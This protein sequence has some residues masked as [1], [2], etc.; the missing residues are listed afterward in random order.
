MVNRDL[1]RIATMDDTDSKPQ[2]SSPLLHHSLM[3]PSRTAIVHARQFLANKQCEDGSWSAK[4]IGSPTYAA[5]LILL[6]VLADQADHELIELAANTLLQSQL[7]EGAWNAYPDGP[8]AYDATVEAYFALKI[9]DIEPWQEPIVR[10]RRAILRAGGL[11]TVSQNSKQI[12]RLFDQLPECYLNASLRAIQPLVHLPRTQGLQEIWLEKDQ[13]NFENDILEQTFYE[14]DSFSKKTATKFSLTPLTRRTEE[15]FAELSFNE[16]FEVIVRFVSQGEAGRGTSETQ[17]LCALDRCLEAVERLVVR[18]KKSDTLY[19]SPFTT[20]SL[21]TIRQFNALLASGQTHHSEQIQDALDWILLR[22]DPANLEAEA[23]HELAELLS[24]LGR[25]TTAEA[26]PSGEALPPTLQLADTDPNQAP[27]WI[28]TPHTDQFE[29]LAASHKEQRFLAVESLMNF[30]YKTLSARQLKEGGWSSDQVTP[31]ADITGLVLQAFGSKFFKPNKKAISKAVHYLASVQQLDGSFSGSCGVNALYATSQI[32]QGLIQVGHPVESD[33]VQ[34][35]KHW[36]LMH[37]QHAG[38]WGESPASRDG[39]ALCGEGPSS[40]TQT[41]WVVAALVEAGESLHPSVE[42][43]ISFLLE[44]QEA[45][46]SWSEPHY[47]L[48]DPRTNQVYRNHLTPITFALG[49]LSGWLVKLEQ[50]LS[51][52]LKPLAIFSKKRE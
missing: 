23:T 47:T 2:Q 29:Q 50:S 52:D 51:T 14:S 43:A 9:A 34:A 41:A 19:V 25:Y 8:A 36:L 32:L 10:A 12:F 30:V 11:H 21:D 39:I 4:I 18:D 26:Q 42:R 7:S 40:A 33:L 27:L 17:G 28:H 35:S 48:I 49:T 38:G 13:A 22:Y 45:D 5:R 46:G 44:T 24:A 15:D 16:L 6:L 1:V 20:K 31:L 3:T 37:Q